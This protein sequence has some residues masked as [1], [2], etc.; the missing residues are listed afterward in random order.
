[1]ARHTPLSHVDAAWLSMEDPTNLMMVNG[2]LLFKETVDFEAFVE[3]VKHRWLR[4]DRFRQHV[5]YP[6]LRRPLAGPRWEFD[7]HFDVNAHVHRIALPAPGDY[8]TLQTL[9]S[10]LTSTPLDYSKPLWQCH[11]IEGYEA[12]T[13][14]MSRLHHAI[15]DGIALMYVLL[16]MA[17]VT[18]EASLKHPHHGGTPQKQRSQRRGLLSS[19]AKR[20]A[21]AVATTRALTSKLAQETMESIT[22][23]G[24]AAELAIDLS[25]AAGRL[26]FRPPDPKTILKGNLGVAKKVAW[27]HALSLP[28]IKM[29]K[30]MCGGTVN[31]VLVSALTGS[32]RRYLMAQGVSV[33]GLSFRAAM[34]VNIRPPEKMEDLGNQFGIVYPTLPIGIADPEERMR[35]VHERMEQIKA[36]HEAVVA[37]GILT[38]IGVS[39]AEAQTRMVDM[40]G[41][42]ASVVITNVPGPQIPLYIAGKELDTLMAWVPQ[43]GRVSLGLSII[44]YNNKVFIGIISD[45][46]LVPNPNMILAGFYEEFEILKKLAATKQVKGATKQVKAAAQAKVDL[47]RCHALTQSGRQCKNRA[48]SGSQFCHVHR[49]T[50]V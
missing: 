10:D 50:A 44:S 28:E 49:Q 12:G 46:G 27:S 22:N 32:L 38:G 6:R 15:A 23:P 25:L 47:E 43:A 34:P 37:F 1:M 20:T 18:P 7:P 5:V 21:T 2:I 36:S 45:E 8:A 3:V 13:V 14:I 16:S 4:F 40:F 30:N 29:I 19:L 39:P 42:K 9:I 41:S 24:H 31:D 17:D 11:F 35:I 33:D 26:V 48:L